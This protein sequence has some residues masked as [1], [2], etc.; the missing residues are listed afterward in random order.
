MSS[1]AGPYVFID[2]VRNRGQHS[3]DQEEEP[4]LPTKDEISEETNEQSSS[5]ARPDCLRTSKN[6]PTGI[7]IH[8]ALILLY[9]IVSIAIIRASRNNN[10]LRP[11]RKQHTA[12]LLPIHPYFPIP[13]TYTHTQKKPTD[14]ATYSRHRQPR[15]RIHVDHLPQSE[16]QPLRR[17]PLTGH[18]RSMDGAALAHAY[19]CIGSGAPAR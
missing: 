8:A 3:M 10:P 13:H 17:C 1:R 5:T 2:F 7:F 9:T 14:T 12:S 15:S 18:R 19:P 11:P 4:F 16:Q 6:F